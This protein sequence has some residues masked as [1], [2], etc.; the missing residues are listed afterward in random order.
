MLE[1][2]CP[3]ETKRSVSFYGS[4]LRMSSIKI[5]RRFYA[6]L[7]A[8]RPKQLLKNEGGCVFHF[9]EKFKVYEMDGYDKY[10]TVRI[11]SP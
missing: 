1:N 4:S 9:Y 11:K 8:F 10:R 2:V 7:P 3:K 5:A 6:T